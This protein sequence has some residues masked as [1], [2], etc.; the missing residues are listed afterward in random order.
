VWGFAALWAALATAL[1]VR[2]AR[3]RLPFSLT[4][5]SFTFPVG[6]CVTGTIA[7]AGH[8]GSDAFRWAAVALY[9]ILVAAWLVV[10]VRTVR[11]GWRGAL[12]RPARPAG[13]PA[14]N[15]A[16][17]VARLTPAAE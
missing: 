9:L 8:T 7:L 17:E 6:T 15:H 10:S 13:N 11:G 4:W 2:A 1:T 3:Q 5:W 14:G 12:L 16:D